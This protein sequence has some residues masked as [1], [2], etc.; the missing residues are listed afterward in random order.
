MPNITYERDGMQGLYISLT[1]AALAGAEA[2]GI[3]KDF[4]TVGRPNHAVAQA[5]KSLHAETADY[6]RVVSQVLMADPELPAPTKMSVLDKVSD[7]IDSFTLAAKAW[8]A[9]ESG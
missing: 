8:V 4:E 5:A 7:L 3:I 9:E 2:R 6:L 1:A